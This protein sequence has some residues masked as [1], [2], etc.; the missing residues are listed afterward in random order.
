MGILTRIFFLIK[1]NTQKKKDKHL[2]LSHSGNVDFCLILSAGDR[3]Y[4]S[5]FSGIKYVYLSMHA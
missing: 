2:C 3:G 4:K 5:S 1:K